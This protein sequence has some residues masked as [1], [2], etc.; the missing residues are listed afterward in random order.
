MK[1]MTAMYTMKRGGSYDRF[2]MMLEAFL[3]RGCAV[4]C[5][6]LTPI[7]VQNPCF[8]NHILFFPFR[9]KENS[10][11][12]LTVFF[13]FP[14]FS[15]W[16]GWR[17]KIDLIIAFGSLYAFLLVF[18]KRLLQRP[19]VTFIRGNSS[20]GLRMQDS[21]A[22]SLLLSKMIEY[23]GLLFSDKIITN[24]SAARD[25]ISRNLGKKKNIDVQVLY[26]NIPAMDVRESEHISKTKEKYGIPENAKVLVTAGVL[27]RG[28]NIELLLHCMAKIEVRNVYVLIA[29][30]GSTEGDLRYKDFLQRLI[31]ELKL[32]KKVI[33]TGWLAKEEL[34]KVYLASDLFVLPSLSEGMPNA[35]LEALGSNLPCF[36]SDVSGIRDILKH[37]Q[38]IF[39]L[40]DEKTLLGRI[41]QFFT[42]WQFFDKTKSLCRER[43]AAFTFDWKEKV[44]D[45][46][47][48]TSPGP[49]TV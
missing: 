39:D 43:K 14:L 20:F 7:Q 33:F 47:T 10:M 1:I 17:N 11:A 35:M 32:N 4:H 29:G 8:Y 24:N 40:N 2:I 18:S 49:I 12:K 26:N 23:Y 6:S 34:W 3:E 44:F 16:M 38:L 19:M 45:M 5:L 25:E 41:S 36:G 21:S 9:N 13:F 48:E 30:E 46:T 31:E 27:N 42:D 37:E 28:K 22:A 15:V